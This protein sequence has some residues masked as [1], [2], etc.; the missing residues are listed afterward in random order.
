MLAAGET[1]PDFELLN[2]EGKPVKLSNYR[3]KKVVLY[4]YPEDFTT[5]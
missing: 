5:G 2:D 3:G 4:F 1:A